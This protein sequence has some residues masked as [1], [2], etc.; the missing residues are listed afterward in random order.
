MPAAL[1]PKVFFPI[2]EEPISDTEANKENIPPTPVPFN[3]E[4]ELISLYDKEFTDPM[5]YHLNK[6]CTIKKLRDRKR[7]RPP[8]IPDPAFSEDN[9]FYDIH[10]D[11]DGNLNGEC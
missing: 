4:Q 10:G 3:F 6:D 9:S 2:K 7:N 8:V 5:L 1:S 11:E